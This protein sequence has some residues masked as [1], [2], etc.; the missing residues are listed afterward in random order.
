MTVPASPGGLGLVDVVARNEDHEATLI[1]GFTWVDRSPGGTAPEVTAVEPEHADAAGGAV[2]VLTG[3]GLDEHTDVRFGTVAAAA[4]EPVSGSELHVTVPELASGAYAVR[5][6]DAQKRTGG[7]PVAFVAH[8]ALTDPSD[9]VTPV[10]GG[11][12]TSASASPSGLRAL[13]L[14][15]GLVVIFRWRRPNVGAPALA[16]ALAAVALSG[17]TSDHVLRPGQHAA[18]TASAAILDGDEP[19]SA[20]TVPEGSRVDLTGASSRGADGAVLTWHWTLVEAPPGSTAVIEEAA[21]RGERAQLVTDEPGTYL[22][23]LVVRDHRGRASHA[24]AVVLEASDGEALRVRLDWDAAGHDLDLH[25]VRSEGTCF[26]DGDC[27][28]GRPQPAWGDVDLGADDPRLLQDADGTQGA[29]WEEVLLAAPRDGTY[30]VLVHRLNDRGSLAE[31]EATLTLLRDGDEVSLPL[32]SET[33]VQG[34]VWQAFSVA[35]PGG[36]AMIDQIVTHESLGGPE[37]N[38]AVTDG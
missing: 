17:C 24:D 11:C 21:S 13:L 25:L 6:F 31:V 33:L 8:D 27:F 34:E 10:P 19:V 28:F 7:R 2:L 23:Q 30:T 20:L 18:P 14:M 35:V 29:L 16:A 37:L 36:E 38:R 12:N 32:N 5:V 22:V 3:V 26:G 4:V 15:L 1:G 9:R